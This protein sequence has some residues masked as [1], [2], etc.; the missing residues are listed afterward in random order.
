MSSLEWSQR[1]ICKI[2]RV[3]FSI[4]SWI[5]SNKLILMNHYSALLF[6]NALLMVMLKNKVFV[7]TF[8]VSV[9]ISSLEE[10]KAASCSD[11]DG[12]LCLASFTPDPLDWEGFLGSSSSE[13]STLSL[14]SSSSFF[15]SFSSSS[16]LAEA[17]A[18]NRDT[19]TVHFSA[20]N[21]SWWD[22][23]CGEVS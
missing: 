13:D 7:I 18:C 8:W 14:I 11:D 5:S 19:R 12:L 17:W 1:L 9:G 16:W 6:L 2:F 23:D 21:K 10:L 15:F 3:D 22:L 4:K 20:F